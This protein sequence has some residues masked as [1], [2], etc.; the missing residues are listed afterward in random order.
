MGILWHS[1]ALWHFVALWYSVAFC[2][3]LWHSLAFCGILWHC[4]ILAFFSTVTFCGIYYGIRWHCG[5]LW[6]F[7][8]FCSTVA[9]CETVTF[10]GTVTFCGILWHCGTLI[11]VTP[12]LCSSFSVSLQTSFSAPDVKNMFPVDVIYRRIQYYDS[13]TGLLMLCA[14]NLEIVRHLQSKLCGEKT[15]LCGKL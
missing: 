15:Q 8:E 1:L 5:I 13:M 11:S 2:G 9:F 12:F 3:I 14:K 7:V 10:F 6:H 4:G